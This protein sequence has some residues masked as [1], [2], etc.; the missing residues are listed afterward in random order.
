MDQE[1]ESVIDGLEVLSTSCWCETPSG[2]A[3]ERPAYLE[4]R[5]LSRLRS[6]FRTAN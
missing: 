2:G 1:M 5:S 4:S 3:S 6:G